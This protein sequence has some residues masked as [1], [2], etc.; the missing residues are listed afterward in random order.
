MSKAE[1][2]KEKGNKKEKGRILS[3]VDYGINVKILTLGSSTV[4]K[5][6]FVW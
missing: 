4:G 5:T 6:T 3:K 1:N 2:E